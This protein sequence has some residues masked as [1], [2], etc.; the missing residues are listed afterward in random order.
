MKNKYIECILQIKENETGIIHEKTHMCLIDDETGRPHIFIW[1][2]GNFACDCNRGT[3][4]DSREIE[5]SDGLFSIN[6]LDTDKT[7]YYYQEF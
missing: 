5:C 7:I 6:L 2:E 3:F 1:E 4:F